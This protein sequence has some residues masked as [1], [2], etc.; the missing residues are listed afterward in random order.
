MSCVYCAPKSRIRIRSAWMSGGRTPIGARSADTVVRRF[1]RDGNV[2]HVAFADTGI[3]DAH[4]ARTRAHL[5]DVAAARVAH[6]CAESAREL[7]QD[8][9]DAAFVRNAPLD[10]LGHELLELLGRVLEITVARAMALR[11]RA[12]RA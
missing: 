12:E 10:A 11:H 7:V 5:L 8:R 1:F 4:K 3:R 6:R 2:V 9:H